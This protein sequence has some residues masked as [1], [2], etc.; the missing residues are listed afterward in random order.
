MLFKTHVSITVFAILI[1]ISHVEYK[2]S[3]VIMALV[4]TMIPDI[5]TPNSKIGRNWYFRPFQWIAKHRGMFHSFT[6]LILITLIF[7]FTFPKLALGFFL[8]YGLHLL[9]DGFT[10]EGVSVLYPLGIRMNGK[11]RTGGAVEAGMFV[12][13][14]IIDLLFLI[15]LFS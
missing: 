2:T 10:I 12:M 3:F 11:L 4:A 7:C 15:A 8:G 5:D 9:V 14:T 6:F 1:L 13:F